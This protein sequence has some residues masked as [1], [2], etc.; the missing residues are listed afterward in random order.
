MINHPKT[1]TMATIGMESGFEK[2]DM[3]DICAIN[4]ILG[5]APKVVDLFLGRP[6]RS[7]QLL[8]VN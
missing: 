4:N 8:P 7:S 2:I 1:P 5:K 6:Q 3:G